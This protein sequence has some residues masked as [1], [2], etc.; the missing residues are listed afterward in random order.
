MKTIG[1]VK[2]P[3]VSHYCA[4]ALTKG[5]NGNNTCAYVQRRSV[6]TQ[7]RFKRMLNLKNRKFHYARFG[8]VRATL[9]ISHTLRVDLNE[10]KKEGVKKCNVQR[11]R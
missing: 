6:H 2:L 1:T 10:L 8:F 4:Q 11:D 7:C 5:D 9:E 3:Q